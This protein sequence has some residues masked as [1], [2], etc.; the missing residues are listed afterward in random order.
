MSKHWNPLHDLMLLQERMNRFFEDANERRAHGGD[1][2]TIDSADWYPAAD[3]YDNESAYLIAVDLPGVERSALEI[4]LDDDKL[5]IRGNR[6]ID[7]HGEN[8]KHQA[9]RPHGRFRKSF[10]LP[11]DVAQDGIQAAYSNGVLEVTLP[12][13]SESRGQRIQI[14]VQ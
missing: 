6:M 9:T 4:D 2:D 14:K 11:R 1:S 7:S 10:A 13:H 5:V 12:K 3:V 8:G